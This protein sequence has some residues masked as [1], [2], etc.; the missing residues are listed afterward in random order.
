[1]EAFAAFRILLSNHICYNFT[2]YFKGENTYMRACNCLNCGAN[3]TIDDSNRDFSFCQYCGSKIMFDDYYSTQRI[4]DEAKIKQAE[5]DRTIR[6]K[7][8]ELEENRQSQKNTFKNILT[9]I[10]LILSFI[11][12][13]I[14]IFKWV[15]LDDFIDGVSILMYLGG[16]V[17]GGGAYLIFKLLPEKETDNVLIRSGGIKF[18]TSL[19]P[20][21][22]KNFD[23]AQNILYSAGFHNITCINMHDL[24]LGLLQKPG[25]VESITINNMIVSSVNS[26]GKIY[27]PDSPIVIKYHGK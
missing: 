12:L 14:G 16:P 8:L 26:G 10:W 27:L 6:L 20:F 22:E 3:I 5:T 18:P 13:I 15:V 25:R 24:T 2:N 4:V 7:E 9:I 19:A 11:I 1:M 23:A 21:S 17:I